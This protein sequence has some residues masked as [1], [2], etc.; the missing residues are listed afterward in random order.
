MDHSMT[1]STASGTS[2]TDDSGEDRGEGRK[3]IGKK[4][5]KEGAK[6]PPKK[7]KVTAQGNDQVRCACGYSIKL[8]CIPVAPHPPFLVRVFVL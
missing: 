4:R 2:R 3:E 1:E 8:C 7:R 6:H 5:R